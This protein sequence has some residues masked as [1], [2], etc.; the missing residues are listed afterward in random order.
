MRRLVVFNNVTL[1]GYFSGQNGDISWAKGH[2]D[3][4]FKAGNTKGEGGARRRHGD[5]GKRQHCFAI[6]AGA[7]DQ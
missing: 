7:F 5:Y 1:D 2:Q 4:E 3:P 6:V